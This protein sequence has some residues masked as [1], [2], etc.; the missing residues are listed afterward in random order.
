MVG[1]LKDLKSVREKFC[2]DRLSKASKNK[3]VEWT[4]EDVTNV[5]KSLKTGKSKDPYELPNEIF[6]HSAAGDDLI[7]ALTKLTNRIKHERTFP[8]AMNICNVTNLYK[9]KG[10]K[11][12]FDSYKGLFR[13]PV[14]R[15]I[16]DKLMYGDEYEEI[17]EQLTDCNVGSRRI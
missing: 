13:T 3:T 7:L 12:L 14:L 5:L 2:K 4:V 17:D 6:K 15:I 9:N 8:E 11:N 16:L 1:G 10:P